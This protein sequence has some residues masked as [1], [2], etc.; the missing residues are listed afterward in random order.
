MNKV[1][2]YARRRKLENAAQKNMQ[3]GSDPMYD[4]VCEDRE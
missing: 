4:G 2:D 3:H 1:K